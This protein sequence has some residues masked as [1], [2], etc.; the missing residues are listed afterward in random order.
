LPA[1]ER[2]NYLQS[3]YYANNSS[4]KNEANLKHL[5]SKPSYWETEFNHVA[6]FYDKAYGI[7]GSLPAT[8]QNG[9][10]LKHTYEIN[11]PDNIQNIQNCNL[12]A[13]LIDNG[14]GEIV[15]AEHIAISSVTA[16]ENVA[17]GTSSDAI[18]VAENGVQVNATAATAY[19]YTTDGRL[20]LKQ[21][22]NGNQAIALE[23]GSYVVR[24]ESGN[25]VFAKKVVL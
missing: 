18:V 3:N 24:V 5:V 14:S 25:H 1:N 10:V 13:L 6:R 12:V 15:N 20:V 17:A 4:Y 2:K 23:K 19:V 9:D 21:A 22:V 11:L 16:L 8:F 7:T